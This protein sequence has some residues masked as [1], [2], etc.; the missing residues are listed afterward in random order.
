ME[1]KEYKT[2][3][4]PVCGQWLFSDIDTCYGCLHSFVH[5]EE[6]H[7]GDAIAVLPPP[8][9]VEKTDGEWF[10]QDEYM[11]L[12][13]PDEPDEL[14]SFECMQDAQ[15]ALLEQ[16]L[17][18]EELSYEVV[19]KNETS[20]RRTVTR[21]S[22]PHPAPAE[23]PADSTSQS[24]NNHE[25]ADK[26]HDYRQEPQMYQ[27]CNGQEDSELSELLAPPLPSDAEKTLS[28]ERVGEVQDK[29]ELCLVLEDSY[30]QVP[31]Q[32]PQGGLTLGRDRANDIV[33]RDARVSRKHVWIHAD[34]N[35]MH[36]ENLEATNPAR[37][38][39]KEIV[40][41]VDVPLGGVVEIGGILLHVQ[42]LT[43]H[44]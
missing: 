29:G 31:F 37:Y 16:E 20:I 36:F 34:E 22:E 5:H 8:A 15:Q 17:E 9:G 2:K 38:Q 41:N 42:R 28:L 3:Q 18:V 13:E 44:L 40:T 14:T 12:D 30:V 24:S 26:K 19:T 35:V 11:D 32:V 4:C 21:K 43:K 39:G 33:V 25:P 10:I 6:S 27:S 23:K 7:L 1:L